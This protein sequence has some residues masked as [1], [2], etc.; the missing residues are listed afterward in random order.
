M[1]QRS[2]IFTSVT[3]LVPYLVSSTKCHGINVSVNGFMSYVW[4]LKM[5]GIR[6][7]CSRFCFS[8]STTGTLVSVLK[9]DM[10]LAMYTV[11]TCSQNG[12]I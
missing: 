12:L 8:T 7:V 5:K 11:L 3:L 6:S 2:V 9:T 4:K 10:H 1:F